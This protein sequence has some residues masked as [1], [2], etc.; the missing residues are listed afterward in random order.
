M[1]FIYIL[2]I[3]H[4]QLFA[5]PW[6]SVLAVG[7]TIVAGLCLLRCKLGVFPVYLSYCCH[8]IACSK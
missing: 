4:T 8:H 2:S 3:S 7:Y 5:S 1:R 6:C